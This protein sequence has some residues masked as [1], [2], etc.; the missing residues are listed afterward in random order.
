MNETARHF[1]ETYARGSEVDGGWLFAKALQQAQ[2]DYSDESL[3]RLEQLLTAIR[4]RAKPSPETLQQELP[5]CNFCSLLA[6]YV[7]EVVRRRTG[8]NLDWLDR[9]GALRVFPAGTQLP[10]TSSTRLIANALDQGAA[11]MPV[12]WVEARVLG[13]DRQ[14]S[15]DDYVAS[16]VAQIERDGPAVWWTGMHALGQMASWQMMLAADGG[17]VQPTRLIS[18]APKNFEILVGGDVQETLQRAGRLMEE[19][20]EGAAWQVLSYD[21]FADLERGRFD[22]VMVILHTYGKA[23]LRLKVGF[24]YRPARDGRTFAI[25]DP[26]LLGANVDN[27]KVAR[28]NGAMER[29]I[30]SI[31]WAFGTT[32][33]QLRE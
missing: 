3:W 18:T 26:V 13:N 5:G 22:A 30:Q 8:A 19:N 11:F 24:P 29:G 32:W 7:I 31:K 25:L 4:K 14:V 17:A 21:G 6:Y 16:V 33:N 10:D 15:V 9:A 1:L 2:L 20:Q 27:A 28:L 12:G 23:P